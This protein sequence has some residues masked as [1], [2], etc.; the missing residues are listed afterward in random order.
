MILRS[1]IAGLEAIPAYWTLAAGMVN[2]SSN[3]QKA[4]ALMAME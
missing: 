4:M 2:F 1:L 3:F